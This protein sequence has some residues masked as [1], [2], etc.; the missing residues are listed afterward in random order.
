MDS[1]VP[2]S[3]SKCRIKNVEL[4]EET[5]GRSRFPVAHDDL[6]KETDGLR[7]T[8][9]SNPVAVNRMHHSVENPV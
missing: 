2:F 5:L 3:P 7:M 1:V 9:Q 4:R 8:L 6:L